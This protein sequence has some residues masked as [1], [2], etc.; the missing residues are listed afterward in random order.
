MMYLLY[1]WNISWIFFIF[2]FDFDWV[3]AFSSNCCCPWTLIKSTTYNCSLFLPIFVIWKLCTLLLV[4]WIYFL[5]TLVICS[6]KLSFSLFFSMKNWFCDNTIL[7]FSFFW[8]I[9]NRAL[10]WSEPIQFIYERLFDKCTELINE[11]SV[12]Q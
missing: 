3:S 6:N 11:K 2:N 4:V 1:F 10:D 7:F 12:L 5:L 8:K 9:T